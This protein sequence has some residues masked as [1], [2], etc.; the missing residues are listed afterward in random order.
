MTN[1]EPSVAK[2][3]V[4][5]VSVFQCPRK[6]DWNYF[7]CAVKS[8]LGFAHFEHGHTNV[9]SVNARLIKD[10][11]WESVILTTEEVDF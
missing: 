1:Y 9:T 6:N 4:L 3:G 5:V 10:M 2:T 7:L 11:M 8:L